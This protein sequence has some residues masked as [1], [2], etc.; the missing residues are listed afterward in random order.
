MWSITITTFNSLSRDHY[1]AMGPVGLA[2]IGIFQLP[3]S[4]SPIPQFPREAHRVYFQLPLSGSHALPA[5]FVVRALHLSTPSLGITRGSRRSRRGADRAFNSLSRDH[6]M[7]NEDEAITLV[8]TDF[9][10]PLSG[11]PQFTE[12]AL[13]EPEDELST[14]SLGITELEPGSKEWARAVDFQ[15]P[16]SGSQWSAS[17]SSS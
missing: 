14:P 10:L 1:A 8:Q 16:L 12:E 15:L 13:I 2:L 4:G 3:L 7:L 5:R 11:S 17:S 9:Q 6:R